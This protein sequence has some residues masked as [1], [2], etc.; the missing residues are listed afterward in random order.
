MKAISSVMCVCV[1]V[2]VARSSSLV[3]LTNRKV[4]WVTTGLCFQALPPA[5]RRSEVKQTVTVANL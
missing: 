4:I 1:C 3:C 5:E 2:C